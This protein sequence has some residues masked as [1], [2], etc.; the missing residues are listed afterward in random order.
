MPIRKKVQIQQFLSSFSST[1]HY[2]QVKQKHYLVFE[3]RF[4]KGQITLMKTN[5]RWSTHGKG[6][7][8]SDIKESYLDEDEVIS[9]VWKHRAA[10]NRVMR[11]E[12]TGSASVN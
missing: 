9:L 2:D 10:V 4:R 7:S 8:Y 3:D 12:L 6:K 1:V 11:E 5:G